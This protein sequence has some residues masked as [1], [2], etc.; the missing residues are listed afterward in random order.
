MSPTRA[1]TSRSV[2]LYGRTE[3]AEDVS[4]E[5]DAQ[6]GQPQMKHQVRAIIA[7]AKVRSAKQEHGLAD[8]V[9]LEHLLFVGIRLA[10]ARRR[11]RGSSPACT[12]ALGILPN[13][14]IVE[15]TQEVLVAGYKGQT[16]IRTREK[17]DEAMGGVLFIDEAYALVSSGDSGFGQE[18]IDTLLPAFENSRAAS[19]PSQPG[20]QTRWRSSS[21]RTS[22]S[23]LGSRRPSSSCRTQP[24]SSCR[25][26]RSWRP[27]K[28][29]RS[30]TGR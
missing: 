23:P 24:T 28:R 1:T 12:R 25:S 3:S 16:A 26:R 30:Q 8:S 13:E 21:H 14:E 5:L 4:A 6:V 11:S 9:D 10:R 18:A 17:I 29:R 15:V 7:Q 19:S 2:E 22:D 27:R 20:I